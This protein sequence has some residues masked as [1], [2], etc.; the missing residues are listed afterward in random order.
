MKK[1]LLAPIIIILSTQA[2]FAVSDILFDE[3]RQVEVK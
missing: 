1:I 3:I 2:A